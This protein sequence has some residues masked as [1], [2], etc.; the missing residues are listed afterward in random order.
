LT[1]LH[2]SLGH[3]PGGKWQ[4]DADVTACFTDMLLRSI[5]QLDV[6]RKAVF[7]LGCSFV[8]PGDHILD[9]GC[10]LGDS[11][12][13][14]IRKYGAYC[15]YTGIEVSA[16]MRE[17]AQARFQDRH[18]SDAYGASGKVTIAI[19]DLDL[20][21][22]YPDTP[23]QL[24]LAILTLMFIPL[25]HR[26]QVLRRM[27]QQTKPGGACL[28]VE[29]ILGQTA[30]VAQ[31]FIDEYHS[32]KQRSG[33]TREE[34]DRKALALEGVLVP[35]TAAWNEDALHSAGFQQVEC[36]WRWLNFAGW[37]ALK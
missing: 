34:I 4:F 13:P 24:T 17:Q 36:F 28:I 8:H 7:T 33:Y 22:H 2:S 37:L 25:E 6:M 3:L 11:L 20:R 10:S 32:F 18:V 16:P 1:A 12:E 27:W 9:L 19:L 26:M 30:E 21:T 35:M 31:L 5:P 29:K 23:S 15:T 14:F